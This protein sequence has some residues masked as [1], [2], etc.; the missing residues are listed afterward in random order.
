MRKAVSALISVTERKLSRNELYKVESHILERLGCV[1]GAW[2]YLGER[3]NRRTKF[4]RPLL[5]S[6]CF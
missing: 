1:A 3:K 5:P 2:K 4:L 6:A